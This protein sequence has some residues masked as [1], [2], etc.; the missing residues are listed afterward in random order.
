MLSCLLKRAFDQLHLNHGVLNYITPF[1]SIKICNFSVMVPLI[2]AFLQTEKKNSRDTMKGQLWWHEVHIHKNVFFIVSTWTLRC[3]HLS[4]EICLPLLKILL[5]NWQKHWKWNLWS[6]ES[7][8]KELKQSQEGKRLQLLWDH[9]SLCSPIS[10]P[11]E[12]GHFWCRDISPCGSPALPA[13]SRGPH[14]RVLGSVP[15]PTRRTEGVTRGCCC[16]ALCGGGES[17]QV[18]KMQCACH[19]D[20][21]HCVRLRGEGKE[22]TYCH[23]RMSRE[24]KNHNL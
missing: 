4:R 21:S 12:T 20:C 9:T 15:L 3:S 2:Y 6:P 14:T 18:W 22:N 24:K 19:W 17:A 13:E 10:C 5:L 11:P 1:L 7:S 16:D 23:Q 8:V